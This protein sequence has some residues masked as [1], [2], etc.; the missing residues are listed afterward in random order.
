MNQYT[1]DSIYTPERLD[2]VRLRPTKYFMS[3]G[4]EGL[5]HQALEI[6]SN[7]VDEIALMPDLVGKLVVLLCIDAEHGTYQ[8]AVRDNGRGVPIEKFLDVF[9][10]LDTSGKYNTKAYET[11]GGLFGVGAKATAGTSR[12]FRPI[13]HHIEDRTS[14]SF[15]VHQG[16]TDE[17]IETDNIPPSVAGTTILFEPD[18]IIFPTDIG[19]FSE[20]GQAQL[21]T[22]VQKYCYFRRLD[23]SLRVYPLGLPQDIWTLPLTEAEAIVDRYIDGSQAIFLE[24]TFDR[25]GWIKSYWGIQRPIALQHTIKDDF[26]ASVMDQ[27]TR[28]ANDVRIRYQITFFVVKFDLIGGRF[29]MVN[30]LNIDDHKSTH[31]LT[32]TDSL[33]LALSGCIKDAAIRKYFLEKYR[34][35][36]YMAIDVK[37]PGAQPSGTTKGAFISKEFKKYYEPS[38]R[39]SL[40]TSES[41]TFIEAFYK[42]LETDIEGKYSAEING[43][44]KVK[45]YDRIFEEFKNFSSRYKP[46]RIMGPSAELFLVEGQSAGAVAQGRKDNQGVY[47]MQGKPLNALSTEDAIRQ[48]A[49]EIRDNDTYKEI[50][51][52]TGINPARFDPSTLNYGGIGI[53]N[54]ADDHGKHIASILTGGFYAINPEILSSG[55][56]SVILPPLYSLEYIGKKPRPPKIYLRDEDELQIWMAENVYMRALDVGVKINGHSDT[57]HYL[58]ASDCVKFLSIVLS[59]GQTITNIANELMFDTDVVERLTHVAHA[60]DPSRSHV[61]VAAIKRLPEVDRVDY[62]PNGNVLIMTI[63]RN[64]HVIPLQNVWRRLV[65]VVLPELNRIQWRKTQIYITTKNTRDLKDQPISVMGLYKMLISFDSLF[66]IGRYKGLGQMQPEDTGRTCTD[67]ESRNSFRITSIGDVAHIFELLGNDSVHRKKLISRP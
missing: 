17:I 24:D 12:H 66:K 9:T 2:V 3:T 44:V 59:I 45:N 32:V 55:I 19:L 56:L 46:A 31:F 52:I 40:T 37:F 13:T 49:K 33:K 8:I 54:D 38:V 18:P 60:I 30:N 58:Q 62:D 7:G 6:I 67:P 23:I 35:P 51:A 65:D 4:I 27:E 47:M 48:A 50:L 61:D 15:Y 11:S 10:K 22:V 26:I 64:D 42:D 34:V 5:V 53:L 1:A 36:V 16:K 39:R 63:G 41:A 21:L 25:L 14:A 43:L 20:E 57:V 28:E 29:G